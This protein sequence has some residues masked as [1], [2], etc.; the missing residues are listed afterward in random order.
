MLSRWRNAVRP[1]L[2]EDAERLHRRFTCILHAAV[3]LSR[4]ARSG[5]HTDD[6]ALSMLLE[7]MYMLLGRNFDY[8][9]TSYDFEECT[10][11]EATAAI[12]ASEPLTENHDGWLKLE[13]GEIVFLEK[14]GERIT[15]SVSELSV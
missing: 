11:D 7:P 6:F 3:E 13:C 14:K 2:A 4:R 1:L 8:D 15:R 10:E 9:E 5:P 12:F